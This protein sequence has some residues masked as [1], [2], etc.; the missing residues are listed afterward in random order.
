MAILMGLRHLPHHEGSQLLVD[1]VWTAPAVKGKIGH[2]S[3]AFGCSQAFG[4]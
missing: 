1:R 3:K 2:F 4:L